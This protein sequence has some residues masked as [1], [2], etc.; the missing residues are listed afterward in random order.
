MIP[1]FRKLR[2]T[3]LH[4]AS[5][6]KYFIYA[7]G[8]IILVVI[9]ILIALQIN[10]WNEDRKNRS[11]EGEYYGR[12]LEDI[13]QDG[14]RI[15]TLI[16]L[17]EERLKA[18]NQAVRLLQQDNPR[19]IEVGQQNALAIKAI[20][21]DFKPSNSAFEDLK[22]GANLNIIQDKSVIKAL[23]NYYNDIES[24]KSVI[25][26]NGK[27]AV[28]I[29]YAHDDAF[30]TGKTQA[31]ILYGRFQ[32]GMEPDVRQAIRVDTTETITGSMKYRLYNEAVRYTSANTRQVEL[33]NTIKNYNDLVHDLLKR[34][35]N[36]PND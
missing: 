32:D 31:S 35:C 17:S 14:E 28:D 26:I 9:G 22:S 8:E 2:K 3:L 23:N 20:Y 4:N 27:N 7:I 6:H 12:L 5:F 1:F 15:G 24:I 10:N 18:S 13:T 25:Q 19:K 36:S 11:L 21:A 34:K 16:K 33:Y 29:Y 30:A